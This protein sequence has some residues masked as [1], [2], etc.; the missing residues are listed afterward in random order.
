MTDTT[1]YYTDTGLVVS[2]DGDIAKVALTDEHRLG[3]FLRVCDPTTF[4]GDP[5]YHSASDLNG[6]TVKLGEPAFILEGA[7]RYIHFPAPLTGMIFDV[8]TGDVQQGYREP[9]KKFIGIKISNPVE[10]STLSMEPVKLSAAIQEAYEASESI[11]ELK[12]YPSILKCLGGTGCNIFHIQKVGNKFRFV[13]ACDWNYEATLTK[14][15][16]LR[17]S[18]ELRRMAELD[19]VDPHFLR[20]YAGRS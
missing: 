14:K 9:P 1:M 11:D 19:D 12:Q 15:Q 18:D 10:L 7:Y 16:L 20:E 4:Y 5:L 17:L 3:R 2:V 6:R 8:E 13:D